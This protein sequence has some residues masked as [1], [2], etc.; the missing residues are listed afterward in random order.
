MLF[1]SSVVYYLN[2]LIEKLFY[3][4][5]FSYKESSKFYVDKLVSQIIGKIGAK[6][7]FKTPSSLVHLGSK[8]IHISMNKN[9]TWYILFEQRENRFL[10]TYI[11]NNYSQEASKLSL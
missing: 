2:E 1:D 10:V 11:F 9:T 7:H 3:E 4:D 5:Y 8:F 6:K